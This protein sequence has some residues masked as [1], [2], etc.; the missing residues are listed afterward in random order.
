M[1]EYAHIRAVLDPL[2]LVCLDD[3]RWRQD[4]ELTLTNDPD[5]DPPSLAD[6]VCQLDSTRA[7]QLAARL[8]VLADHAEPRPGARR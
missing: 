6:P 7:R 4:I 5:R 8:L 3:G 1:S 2:G